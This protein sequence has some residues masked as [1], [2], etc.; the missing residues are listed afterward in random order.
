[1]KTQILERGDQKAHRTEYE[2]RAAGNRERFE[3]SRLLDKI[4]KEE[5]RESKINVLVTPAVSM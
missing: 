1:M 2:I 3:K 5:S 4:G